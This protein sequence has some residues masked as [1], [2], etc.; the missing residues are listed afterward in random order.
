MNANAPSMAFEPR[1]TSSESGFLG[2]FF[3]LFTRLELW[4]EAER[5]QLPLWLPV[6]LGAGICAW[7]LLPDAYGWMGWVCACLGLAGLGYFLPQGTRGQQ[8]V[9]IGGMLGALGLVLMWGKAEFAG[10]PPLPRPVFTAF[11]AEVLDVEPLPARHLTRVGLLPAGRP[12]LPG[13]VRVNI[14][15]K[16]MPDGLAPG[17]VISLRA[18]LMPPAGPSVPGAYDFAQRAYFAGIGA[19]GKVLPPIRVEKPGARG[20]LSIRH[21]LAAYIAGRLEGGAGGIAA[22]LATGDVGAI[23]DGD[24]NAMRRSGLAHLLSISGLHVTALIGGV[25]FLMRRLLALS[26]RLAL[27]WPLMLVA[28]GGGALAGIGYTLLTGAEVPTIRS[29]VAALLVLGGMALGRE[30]ITLRLI[31]AGAVFVLIFWPESLM[32]PSFQLSFAAVVA[33]VALHE[34]PRFRALVER[35]DEGMGRRFGRELF[36][37]LLTGIVVEMVLA[38]IALFH[39]HQS[40]LL[41]AFA[42]IVAIPLTTFIVMPAEALALM[43][44][45]AGLGAPAWWVTGKALDLLLWVAHGAA[46]QD[47]AVTL[48]PAFSDWAFGLVVIGGLWCVLWKSGARW[49][50][51][52]PLFLGVA[53]ILI[54]PAPDILVTGDGRHVAVH[55]GGKFALLRGRAGRYVRD[56]LSESAGYSGDM[57]AFEAL[58]NARCSKDLCAVALNAGGRRW[59]LLATRSGVP[60]PLDA[61]ARDCARSDIVVSERNLPRSCMPHWLRLDRQTLRQTGGVALFLADGT[62][63]TVRTPGDSHPW[64]PGAAFGKSRHWRPV[65]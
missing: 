12:D 59:T 8:A 22:A 16:D 42:N 28:G 46:R 40:G 64:L 30:A 49:L 60:L 9:M 53:L 24:A 44:D 61:L 27:R 35:R 55:V 58:P 5:T 50:G 14:A 17:A 65:P 20:A 62:I 18:R 23:S 31:A 7:F 41:G 36:S 43:L 47:W 19:T 26:S 39:F 15:G 63:R 10:T 48:R 21:R 29:C 4:L 3:A 56:T 37:L 25:M 11:S 52:A 6:G 1:Q 34:H 33:I 57:P 38:P 45:A 2:R 13:R 32:G 51:L 54:A